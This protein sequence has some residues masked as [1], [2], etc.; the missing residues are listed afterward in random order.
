VFAGGRYQ[1]SQTLLELNDWLQLQKKLGAAK[2][3]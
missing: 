2:K 1:L 3:K